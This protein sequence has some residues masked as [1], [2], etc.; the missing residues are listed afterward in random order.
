MLRMRTLR[1]L[2]NVLTMKA[3]GQGA[4]EYRRIKI[5][6]ETMPGTDVVRHYHREGYAN[7][8]LGGSFIEA[9]FAGRSHVEPGDVLL[10]GA[11]D[12][13]ANMGASSRGVRV[14][15]LPWSEAVREGHFRVTD[16]DRTARLAEHDVSA[17]VAD[18][19]EQ[20]RETPRREQGWP[21][22]LADDLGQ[23]T[24]FRMDHWAEANGLTPETV[25]RAFRRHFGVSPQRFRLETRSRNAWR[26][27]LR[28]PSSLTTIAHEVGFADLAHMTRGIADL[29]GFPPSVWRSA[30]PSR[31]HA[32]GKSE[33]CR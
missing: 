1:T 4:I 7:V 29:T 12:A 5:G 10:H 27:V 15:R 17:A 6:V 2:A 16:P 25:S 31:H 3:I 33:E 28:D 23:L 14:L 9:G 19:R 13:H 8:I 20:V 30:R 11:F 24:S 26:R 21:E 22:R 32:P 18:L